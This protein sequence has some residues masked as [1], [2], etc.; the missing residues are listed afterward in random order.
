MMDIMNEANPITWMQLLEG[1]I[2]KIESYSNKY[3]ES[4]IIVRCVGFLKHNITT[5][6]SLEKS[7]KHSYMT[8]NT[9]PISVT[10][11]DEKLRILVEEYITMQ[12][13]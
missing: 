7:Y 6:L 13:K 8:A 3:Q 5:H 4:N 2:K 1:E 10:Y 12:K 11:T 9:N